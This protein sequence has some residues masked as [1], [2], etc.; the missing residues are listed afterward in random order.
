MSQASVALDVLGQAELAGCIVAA[1]AL[2][3]WLAGL[4]IA[5]HGSEPKERADILRAYG[6]A[7]PRML[8]SQRRQLK[9]EEMANTSGKPEKKQPEPPGRQ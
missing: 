6:S 1:V 3:V 7:L 8:R 2:I 9:R 4:V 5:L